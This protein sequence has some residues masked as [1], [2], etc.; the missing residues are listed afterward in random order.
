[1]KLLFAAP[2]SGLPSDPIALGAQASRLHFVIK[3]FFAAP[4]SGF[5]FLPTALL[6]HVSCATAEP[7]ANAIARSAYI[8]GFILSSFLEVCA[9]LNIEHPQYIVSGSLLPPCNA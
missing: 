9:H 3:L 6:A 8:K 7:I 4:T 5:P 2:L 1:M